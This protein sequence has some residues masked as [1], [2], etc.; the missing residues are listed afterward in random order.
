[1]QSQEENNNIIYNTYLMIILIT[2]VCGNNKHSQYSGAHIQQWSVLLR[3]C[4]YL[5][6]SIS[7][8]TSSFEMCSQRMT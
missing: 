5:W 4:V 2:R 6:D 1:M 7:N 3:Y 8:E